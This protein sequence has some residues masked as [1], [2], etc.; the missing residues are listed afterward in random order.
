MVPPLT[1]LQ[2]LYTEGHGGQYVNEFTAYRILY[3]VHIANFSEI[4]QVCLDVFLLLFALGVSAI[5][6]PPPPVFAITQ[7]SPPG[8]QLLSTA[9][10]DMLADEGVAH[11][12]KV[13]AA[14]AAENFA[15]LFRLY[16]S[17]PNMGA[18]LMDMFV[19]R[20]RLK[21]YRV[22]RLWLRVTVCV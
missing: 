6:L 19:G 9:S 11:A 7:P 18:Y 14:V 16:E 15:R 22:R 8:V 5:S 2:Q 21:A 3:Y 4:A 17:A 12:L 10:P 13:R 20:F 1:Q